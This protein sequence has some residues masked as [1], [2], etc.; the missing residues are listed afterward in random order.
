VPNYIRIADKLDILFVI[1]HLREEDK[2]ECKEGHGIDPYT[3]LMSTLGK[4]YAFILP[5]GRTAGLFGIEEGGRIWM[6]CTNLIYK[7]PVF[8]ARASKRFI[9]QC[10]EPILWNIADKRN[11]VHLKLLKYLGFKF[12]REV[13]YGPNNLPFIEFCRCVPPLL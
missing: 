3:S 9:D 10:N 4:S 8:I 7:Y 13:K 6:L 11:T 2:R 5:D 1:T 12:L